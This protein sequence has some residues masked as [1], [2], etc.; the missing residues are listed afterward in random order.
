MFKSLPRIALVIWLTGIEAT[1]DC[2]GVH[3]NAN[4]FPWVLLLLL[5]IAAV[6]GVEAMRH[7]ERIPDVVVQL[8]IVLG[9]NELVEEAILKDLRE[10]LSYKVL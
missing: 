8:D 6:V 9:Q 5:G 7:F 10:P 2:E 3:R 1:Q 4:I